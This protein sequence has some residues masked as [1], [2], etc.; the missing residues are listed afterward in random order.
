MSLMSIGA[1]LV[2]AVHTKEA[3]DYCCEPH[4]SRRM[5]KMSAQ[6]ERSMMWVTLVKMSFM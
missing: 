6:K 2:A 5:R 4:R 3:R 1:P